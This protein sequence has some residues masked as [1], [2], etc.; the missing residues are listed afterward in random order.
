M[1]TSLK[2]QVIF[3]LIGLLGDRGMGNTKP[4]RAEKLTGKKTQQLTELL[5]RFPVL[6]GFP[7]ESWQGL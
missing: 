4:A 5:S 2:N 3:L 7:T 6:A 1:I